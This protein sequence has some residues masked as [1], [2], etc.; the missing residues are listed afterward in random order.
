MESEYTWV[1]NK[2]LRDEVAGR[3]A[4]G[5]GVFV[6]AGCVSFALDSTYMGIFFL[7]CAVI[8]GYFFYT[9]SNNTIISISDNRLRYGK[10]TEVILEE[11]DDVSIK[12]QFMLTDVLVVKKSG[13]L[14][15]G[16]IS[17]HGVPPDVRDKLIE[18]IQSKITHS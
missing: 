9:T 6:A 2:P 16:V 10:S 14:A 5:A 15:S 1:S 3:V 8:S 11:V 13:S 18:I 17:L 12:R 7:F 4:A